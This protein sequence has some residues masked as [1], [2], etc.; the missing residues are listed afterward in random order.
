GKCVETDALEARTFYSATKFAGE[1]LI[2]QY[3][4]FFRT[5]TLRLFFLYGPG[6]TGMLVSAVMDKAL[7]GERIVIE[8]DPGMH[9][10]PIFVEDAVSAFEAAL[11][12]A[13]SAV[14]NVAGDEIVSV[15]EL[16]GLIGEALGNTPFVEHKS[17]YSSG[18]LVGD[19]SVMKTMLGVV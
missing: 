13:S 15:T 12:L 19:N 10:N 4:E 16:V 1:L 6:Q 9:I 2:S 17:G 8:G 7:S 18:Y 14:I 5:I 11:Q 3:S